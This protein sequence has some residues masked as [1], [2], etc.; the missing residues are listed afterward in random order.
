[1]KVASTVRRGAV[2][3]GTRK[4][5]LAGRPPYCNRPFLGPEDKLALQ[6][7]G[8][9]HDGEWKGECSSKWRITDEG[10]QIMNDTLISNINRVVGEDDT[11]Y[12]L[13]DFAFAHKDVYYRKCREYRDRIKCRNI[14]LIWGNH[15]HRTIRDLF[16]ETYDLYET[17]V[18]N[19]RIVLCH[20]AMA[21]WN[22]SHRGNWHLYGHSHADAEPWLNQHCPGRRSVDVGVDN[23]YKLLGEFRPFSF[24]E[25]V[26]FFQN[27]H[28]FSFDHHINPNSPTEE[29][30]L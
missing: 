11:L 8:A 30:L 15:D 26:A 6:R 5:Y 17:Q 14:V 10:V 13:G 1:M 2:G 24:D 18:N 3:K 23:A 25:L 28:G 22:K 9:W 4:S 27:K 21:T 29:S 20:Y 19:Q 16:N 12:H 7:D